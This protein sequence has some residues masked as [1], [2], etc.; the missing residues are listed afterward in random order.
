M[1]V[2]IEVTNEDGGMRSTKRTMLTSDDHAGTEELEAAAV[3]F[4]REACRSNQH[5]LDHYNG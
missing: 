1:T 5:T 4:I 2:I 3:E